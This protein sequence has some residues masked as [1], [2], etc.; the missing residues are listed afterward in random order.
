MPEE[1]KVSDKGWFLALGVVFLAIFISF[2]SKTCGNTRT[3]PT[4]VVAPASPSGGE[5]AVRATYWCGESFED[6]GQIGLAV[7]NG[8]TPA[9]AGML[10]RGKAFQVEGGTRVLSGGEIDMGISLVHITSGF[11]SGR[12]CYITTNALR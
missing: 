8:D 4:V 2:T 10:T 7:A 3:A 9:I 1:N 12:K 6:A 11:Q 5:R